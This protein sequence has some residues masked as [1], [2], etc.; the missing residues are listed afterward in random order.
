M[1][2]ISKKKYT[3]IVVFI[4]ILC[5]VVL[6][7][8]YKPYKKDLIQEKSTSESVEET[9]SI[10]YVEI[11]LGKKKIYAEVARTSEDQARGLGG[12]TE[13]SQDS[14]MLFDFQSDGRWGIWMKDMIIPIDVLWLDQNGIIVGIEKDMR[15]ESYPKVYT[16]EKNAR[17]VLEIPAGTIESTGLVIGEKVFINF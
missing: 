3:L 15:P 11:L 4:G 7:N 17:F 16:I 13:I 8:I 2:C 10:E 5:F 14:G 12:R 1:I 9:I 6:I